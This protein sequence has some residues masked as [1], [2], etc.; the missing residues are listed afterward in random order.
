MTQLVKVP[1]RGKK[2]LDWCLV[3][4]PKLFNKPLQLPN[5]GRSDPFSFLINPIEMD[6]TKITGKRRPTFKRE[7]KDSNIRAFGRWICNKSWCDVFDQDSC[8]NKSK[9]FYDEIMNAVNT[10]LPLKKQKTCTQDKRWISNKL[11]SLISKRQTSLAK[12]GKQS[13]VFKIWR[14]KVQW[15]VRTCKEV[16]YKN[17]V[18]NIKDHNIFKWWKEVRKLDCNLSQMEWPEQLLGDAASTINELAENSNNYFVNLSAEFQ[19][20]EPCPSNYPTIECTSDILVD[21]RKVYI[22][23]KKIKCHKS[24]GPDN[25]PNRILRDFAFELSPVLSDIYN[26]IP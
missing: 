18:H 14:N 12:Y 1:T 4:K 9:L 7:M 15:A 26:T 25:I 19:P 3:N 13:R 17:K 5:I 21:S 16:Y 20:L 2:I 11:K 10:L 24:L 22:A 23:L 6:R 8:E